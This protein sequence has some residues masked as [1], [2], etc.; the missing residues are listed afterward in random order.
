MLI[1][2]IEIFSTHEYK[3]A[4]LAYNNIMYILVLF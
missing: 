1:L 4:L 3:G 2:G